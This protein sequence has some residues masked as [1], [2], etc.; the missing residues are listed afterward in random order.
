MPGSGRPANVAQVHAASVECVGATPPDA[1]LDAADADA[2]RRRPLVGD[3]RRKQ[4][5]E[6][7]DQCERRDDEQPPGG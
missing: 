5:H 6:T 1:A 2:F 7:D 3:A 4:R